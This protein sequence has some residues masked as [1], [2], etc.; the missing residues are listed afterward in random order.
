MNEP[1]VR[2][3]PLILLVSD[4]LMMG[5]RVREGVKVAGYTFSSVSTEAAVQ[6][7]L[8]SEP[9]PVAVL[10]ALSV[11]R[12]DP[13]ALIRSLKAEHP[14]LPVLAFAG[15]VEQEKHALAREAGA[16]LVTANSSVAMHLPAL[17]S[18]LLGG[19][20]GDA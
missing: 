10:V 3:L 20:R 7:A 17:L 16:D 15:H 14:T 5:S 4:D 12:L 13:Y 9:R 6:T 2:T 18:R 19:E 8:I 1:A 11:R